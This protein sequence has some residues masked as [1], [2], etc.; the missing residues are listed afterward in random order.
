MNLVLWIT[1]ASCLFCF[2]HSA[3]AG[4][5]SN[6]RLFGSAHMGRTG[7]NV[8]L[9]SSIHLEGKNS[10][11]RLKSNTG[12]FKGEDVQSNPGDNNQEIFQASTVESIFF[13]LEMFGNWSKW[14]HCER[15]DCTQHRHRECIDDSWLHPRL[16]SS[17]ILNCAS[18]YYAE[19]RVC[20][21]KSACAT[22]AML[23]NCGV[24][25]EF[26]GPAFKILGGEISKPN[27]WPWAG[28]VAQTRGCS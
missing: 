15:P 14:S 27:S 20:L 9:H 6:N 28:P 24:R 3:Q 5:N 22:P 12:T 17:K 26:V 13:N 11:V 8:L 21:D 2:T 19:I 7:Q 18:K 23:N 4:K 25:P 10:M 1:L 16:N